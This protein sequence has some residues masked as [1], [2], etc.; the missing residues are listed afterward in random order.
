[1]FFKCFS[2]WI[3]IFVGNLFRVLLV[4]IAIS[5]SDFVLE[6]GFGIINRNSDRNSDDRIALEKSYR[7]FDGDR[8]LDDCN[9][10]YYIEYRNI[11]ISIRNIV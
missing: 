9:V 6:W 1:M 10:L 5:S 7:D 11:W 3:L 2:N 8:D 4:R